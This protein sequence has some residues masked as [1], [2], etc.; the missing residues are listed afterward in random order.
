MTAKY[1]IYKQNKK[2]PPSGGDLEGASNHELVR[3]KIS[4]QGN[5]W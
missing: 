4:F 2:S 5:K 3:S 1:F